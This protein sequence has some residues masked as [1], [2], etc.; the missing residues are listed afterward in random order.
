[1]TKREI[2]IKEIM[3]QGIREGD[4]DYHGT[5]QHFIALPDI[6]I[7]WVGKKTW[8][9]PK[10]MKDMFLKDDDSCPKC[11]YINKVASMCASC[12]HVFV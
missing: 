9:M 1:M 4:F 3:K 11:G 7:I 6:D 12:S 8:K 2:A 5:R 10:D